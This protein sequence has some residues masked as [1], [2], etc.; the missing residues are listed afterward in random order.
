MSTGQPLPEAE[1]L[2]SRPRDC[3][4]VPAVSMNALQPLPE[5]ESL[6]SRPRDSEALPAR[7]GGAPRAVKKVALALSLLAAAGCRALVERQHPLEPV[8]VPVFEE[9]PRLVKSLGRFLTGGEALGCIKCHTFKGIESEGVQA[10]DLTDDQRVRDI[11]A[12]VSRR[13][14]SLDIVVNC[15][16]MVG[17]SEREGWVTRFSEQRVDVWREALD[18]NPRVEN[19]SDVGRPLKIVETGRSVEEVFR[20]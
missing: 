3:E 13:L 1:S 10:V 2:R 17:T 15:A 4:A 12:E 6:R 9:S 8:P 14:G 20:P 19:Q 11:P 18:V 5:A 16:A 7:G